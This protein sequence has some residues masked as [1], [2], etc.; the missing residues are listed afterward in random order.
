MGPRRRGKG[1]AAAAVSPISHP[2]RSDNKAFPAFPVNRTWGRYHPATL[3][4]SMQSKFYLGGSL[5]D[6]IQGAGNIIVHCS[7]G[8]S[9]KIEGMAD[10][11]SELEHCLE[12][13]GS[14]NYSVKRLPHVKMLHRL[15]LFFNHAVFP[16]N[17]L[18]VENDLQQEWAQVKHSGQIGQL[19]LGKFGETKAH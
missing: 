7:A 3:L 19:E 9:E 14:G 12:N 11:E 8:H 18:E 15:L 6:L 17:A 10:M 1:E 2:R 5:P 4:P 16:S 13:F